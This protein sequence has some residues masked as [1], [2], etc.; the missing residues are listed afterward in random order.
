MARPGPAPRGLTLSWSTRVSGAGELWSQ[1]SGPAPSTVC[2]APTTDSSRDHSTPDL[3]TSART[4]G[5]LTSTPGVDNSLAKGD[6]LST[7]TWGSLWEY[8]LLAF[9]SY[10][11]ET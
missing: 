4:P 7:L 3:L 1:D 2:P 6:S 5:P 8:E 10:H 11:L 9:D